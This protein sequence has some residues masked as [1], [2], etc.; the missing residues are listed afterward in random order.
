MNCLKSW[1]ADFIFIFEAQI[2]R[3]H[4]CATE[5]A[6]D[7]VGIPPNP[8]MSTLNACLNQSRRRNRAKCPMTERHPAPDPAAAAQD[9]GCGSGGS[10]MEK[11]IW[12]HFF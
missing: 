11:F 7:A 10:K 2:I 4:E 9:Q 8:W 6:F 5:F 1:L 12:S 3:S